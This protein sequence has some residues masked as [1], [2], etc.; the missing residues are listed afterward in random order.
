MG[1]L[2]TRDDVLRLLDRA[3]KDAGSPEK[4]AK[5][6]GI[7]AT[8]IRRVVKKKML[9]GKKIQRPLGLERVERYRRIK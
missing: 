3:I 9:P 5:Q 8:Y 4:L 7:S 6:W 1:K 2:Q